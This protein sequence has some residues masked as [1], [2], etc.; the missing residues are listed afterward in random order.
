MKL[1]SEPDAILSMP[2]M[3]H[4]RSVKGEKR[5]WLVGWGEFAAKAELSELE[6]HENQIDV[7]KA[8]LNGNQK[9]WWNLLVPIPTNF[10]IV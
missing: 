10:G 1:R 7:S 5:K 4:A 2:N 6:Y 3:S 9:I 8:S